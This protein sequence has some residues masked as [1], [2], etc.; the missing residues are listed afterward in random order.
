LLAPRTRKGADEDAMFKE[1]S[2][3][4]Q[5]SWISGAVRIS[6]NDTDW[7]FAKMRKSSNESDETL[8]RHLS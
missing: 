6:A 5:L 3:P 2:F 8:P 7:S 4:N 1:S